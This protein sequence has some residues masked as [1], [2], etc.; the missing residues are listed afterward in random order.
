[1]A[2]AILILHTPHAVGFLE[3]Q[4]LKRQITA[5]NMGVQNTLEPKAIA[6]TGNKFATKHL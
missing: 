6:T 3:E 1:M 4:D 2:I 5:V